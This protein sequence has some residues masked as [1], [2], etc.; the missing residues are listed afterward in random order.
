MGDTL[1]CC[2]KKTI[3]QEIKQKNNCLKNL[4]VVFVIF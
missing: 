2:L 3:Q 1:V 4:M